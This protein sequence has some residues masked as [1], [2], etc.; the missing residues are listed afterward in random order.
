MR[1]LIL[2]RSAFHGAHFR[3]LS[4]RLQTLRTKRETE[5]FITPMLID[6]TMQL[7]LR[8]GNTREV[9]EH[10]QFILGIS[11][12]RWFEDQFD[13]I[14]TE[15]GIWPARRDYQFMTARG[16]EV[17][18]RGI[19]RVSAGMNLDEST[20]QKTRV[21]VRSN[22]ERGRS[23]RRYGLKMRAEVSE[24]LAA[25]DAKRRDATESWQVFEERCLNG[26]GRELIIRKRF[27]SCMGR[28]IALRRWMQNRDRCPYYADWVRGLLYAQYYVMRYDRAR[29]DRNAQADIQHLLYLRD[30]DGI[31]S[32]DTR[33]MRQAWNDLYKERG[34]VY[35]AVADLS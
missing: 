25:R 33:F 19:H 22:R 21:G 12:S 18:K 32:E 8:D 16:E 14:K 30:V 4:S 26:F 31:V 17:I 3:A 27:H 23:M 20:L 28:G 35:L 15:L 6:E 13:V 1:R 5:I 29:V 11:G 2:D 34:K 10:I 9:L 7:W 24:K